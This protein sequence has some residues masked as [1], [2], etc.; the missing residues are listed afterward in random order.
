MKKFWTFQIV[1]QLD[2]YSIMYHHNNQIYFIYDIVDIKLRKRKTMEING[3]I[4][5]IVNFVDSKCLKDSSYLGPAQQN[6]TEVG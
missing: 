1:K 3:Q 6:L 2:I 4:D 5:E